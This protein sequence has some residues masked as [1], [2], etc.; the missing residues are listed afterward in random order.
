VREILGTGALQG[1]IFGYLPYHLSNIFGASYEPFVFA[2]QAPG[3]F[4]CLGL[5]LCM[6]NLVPS[7]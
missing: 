5:M 6:M 4:I 3:A 7:K 1:D 2:I